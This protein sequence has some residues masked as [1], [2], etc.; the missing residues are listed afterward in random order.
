MNIVK[1]LTIDE[2]NIAL[3]VQKF[4]CFLLWSNIG[5]VQY[6]RIII[7]KTGDM[8][9]VVIFFHSDPMDEKNKNP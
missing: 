6:Y 5:P 2:K 9:I 7:I 1:N 8:I 3:G 4:Y